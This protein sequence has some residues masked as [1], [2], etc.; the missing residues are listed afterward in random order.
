LLPAEPRGET[1]SRPP[2]RQAAGPRAVALD[3]FGE[4]S[5]QAKHWNEPLAHNERRPVMARK[6]LP[7]EEGDLFGVP[8]EDWREEV[9]WEHVEPA[10]AEGL[11]SDGLAGYLFVTKKLTKLLVPDAAGDAGQRPADSA[12]SRSMCARALTT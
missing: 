1:L 5:I 2:A 3:E 6:T 12:V 11:P 10:D 4:A 9:A 7:Y 8:L